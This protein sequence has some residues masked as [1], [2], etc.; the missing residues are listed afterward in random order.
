MPVWFGRR[1]LK[2]KGRHFSVIA[3]HKQCILGVKSEEMCL[4][5]A[6]VIA[7]GRVDNDPKH[8]SYR[9]G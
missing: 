9:R 5:Y 3:H 7:I 8:N 4:A 1:A 2:S 6:L